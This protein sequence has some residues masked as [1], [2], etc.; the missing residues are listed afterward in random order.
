MARPL[1]EANRA[2]LIDRALE[3][4]LTHGISSLSLRPLAKRI[5]VSAAAL[6]YNFTSKEELIIAILKRAGDRQRALFETIRSQESAT[7]YEVCREIW[8]VVST[9]EIIPLF[10]LFFEVYGLALQDRERFPDFFAG[11]I[12]RWLDF[13]AM[14]FARSGAKKSDSRLKA[15]MLLAGFRGFMLDLCATEDYARVNGA[16]EVW[17]RSLHV[18]LTPPARA[19]K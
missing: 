15:T 18:V 2:Q 1:D 12:E 3:D 17:L 4:V 19:T 8:R 13:I 6:L 9:P 16:V 10:R 7:P 11:A 14:P 5:G